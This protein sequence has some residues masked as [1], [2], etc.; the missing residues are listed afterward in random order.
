MVRSQQIQMKA[1][2]RHKKPKPKYKVDN[3]MWLSMKNIHIEK[4]LKKLDHKKIDFYL[5][6]E[7]VSLLY[8]LKL[9]KSM[10]IHNVFHSNF[11]KL[12]VENL[13]PSQINDLLPLIVVNDK[14]K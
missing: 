3:L 12:T 9:L 8:R 6:K 11:L 5:I 1:A 4:L 14:K 7:L 13:L 10:Q 2:N